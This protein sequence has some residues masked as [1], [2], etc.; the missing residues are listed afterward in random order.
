MVAVLIDEGGLT[1][2]SVVEDEF[3]ISNQFGGISNTW[4][5]S[6]NLEELEEPQERKEDIIEIKNQSISS[7]ALTSRNAENLFWVGRLSEERTLVL[8]SFL[9]IIFNRLNENVSSHGNSP[10]FLVVLLKAVTHLTQ[11]YPGF[12]GE[13]GGEMRLFFEKLELIPLINDS[14]KK[15]ANF[16]VQ[17]LLYTINHISEKWNNM[18]LKE[19][20]I[21]ESLVSL[22]ASNRKN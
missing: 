13:D 10:E 7:T 1:R 17:S 19:Y 2:S 18:I 14:K 20:L 8:T 4:I 12:V 3:Q 11:T 6:D 9:K 21:E 15:V 5:I 16:N 22:K